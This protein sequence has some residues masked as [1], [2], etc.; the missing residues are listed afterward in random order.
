MLKIAQQEA[1]KYGKE[2]RPILVRLLLEGWAKGL[3]EAKKIYN[4]KYEK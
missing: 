4:P 3:D 2:L 1:D